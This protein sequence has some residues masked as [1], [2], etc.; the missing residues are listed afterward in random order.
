LNTQ[1]TV[2]ANYQAAGGPTSPTITSLFAVPVA[3]K[4]LPA[5]ITIGSAT[6]SGSTLTLGWTGGSPPYQVQTRAN[7][8]GATWANDPT[9]VI[10]GTSATVT[11]SGNEGYFRIQG[12]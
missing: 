1:L 9:A 4:A 12:Q 3:A 8:S 11:I 5:L 6:R 7:F 10:T 2:T